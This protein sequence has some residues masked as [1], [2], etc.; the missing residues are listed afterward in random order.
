MAG[1]TYKIGEAAMLLN[2]KTH[3]LRFWQTEFPQLTPLRTEKGQRIYT[4]ADLA[5]LRRIKQLLHE[6]GMTI[7]G[8]RRV[9]DGRAVLDESQP[10]NISPVLDRDFIQMVMQELSAL[11]NLLSGR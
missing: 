8:A 6:Q 11:K 7:D 2:L 5:L 1:K 3:V 10:G 4:E 9:L